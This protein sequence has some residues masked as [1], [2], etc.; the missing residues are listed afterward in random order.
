MLI[1]VQRILKTKEVASLSSW[2]SIIGTANVWKFHMTHFL[3]Q[4][5]QDSSESSRVTEEIEEL[6]LRLWIQFEANLIELSSICYTCPSL[7]AQTVKN[8]PAVWETLVRSPGWEDPLEESMATHSRILAWRIPMDRSSAGSPWTEEPAELRSMG[9]Q[10]VGYD[11]ATKH[12]TRAVL[13]T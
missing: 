10:R 4:P 3:V 11:W 7:V 5:I 12:S 2:Q 13:R 6:G 8:P 1:I 9:S